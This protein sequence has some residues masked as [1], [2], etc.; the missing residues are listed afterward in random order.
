M[1]PTL[2]SASTNPRPS[3][4][5]LALTASAS[6][7]FPGT[8]GAQN[9]PFEPA[10][11]GCWMAHCGPP[12]HDQ[13][14]LPAPP[15]GWAHV[16]FRDTEAAGSSFGLGCS[17]NGEIAVCS[18]TDTTGGPNIIAYD[19][20]GTHVY[21]STALNSRAFASAPLVDADGGAIVADDT[22]IVRLDGTG[23][24]LWNTPTDGGLPISPVLLPDDR[25]VIATAGGGPVSL[26]DTT[27]GTL[28]DS[29]TVHDGTRT[30][31]TANTPCFMNNRVYVSMEGVRAPT[32]P[33]APP[34]PNGAL[35][36]LDVNGDDLTIAWFFP[37][38]APSG[39]SPVCS[40]G[41]VFLDAA[42]LNPGDDA[43]LYLAV[44]DRGGEGGLV[45]T[46]P[47]T[48]ASAASLAL[49]PRGGLWGFQLNDRNIFRYNEADGSIIE[50]IDLQTTIRGFG[51]RQASSAFTIAGDASDPTLVTGVISVINIGGA[52]E[53]GEP[54]PPLVIP[55]VVGIDLNRRQLRWRRFVDSI[56]AGQFPILL[57]EA[58]EPVV[59]FST[60]NS[61]VYG[62]RVQPFGWPRPRR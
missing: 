6:L 28:L 57:D 23:R 62:I 21:T 35:V 11:A 4:W 39:A 33:P 50:T 22:R 9:P 15:R 56:A 36:A 20:T 41:V 49:D 60:L 25:V 8:A 18:F 37:F 43:P 55:E 34:D 59:V 29:L 17:A 51:V 32:F 27:T 52:H 54:L 12:L 44:E 38:A 31:Q 14:R 47:L 45:W 19:A 46:A 53:N 58:E 48:A 5:I 24:E 30:F 16:L 7:C 42:G 61:G 26:Y 2:G 3:S 13:A 10:A 40:E 1:R